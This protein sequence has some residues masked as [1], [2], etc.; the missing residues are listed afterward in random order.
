[1]DSTVHRF[2]CIMP[3][4]PT[5]HSDGEF[6]INAKQNEMCETL[7][8][9][10]VPNTTPARG[11]RG[12]KSNADLEIEQLKLIISQ[13]QKETTKL[14]RHVKSQ[15]AK[16][17]ARIVTLEETVA[18]RDETISA[19]Q[20]ALEDLRLQDS[21][22][23][24]IVKEDHAAIEKLQCAVDVDRRKRDD[25]FSSVVKNVNIIDNQRRSDLAVVS[26]P[27]IAAAPIPG[28]ADEVALLLSSNLKLATH[29]INNR[30]VITPIGREGHRRAL[31]KSFYPSDRRELF[32]RV[33]SLKP[34]NLFVND[35]LTR[36]TDT[37]FY[38]AR[39]FKRENNLRIPVFSKKGKIFFK[40][41]NA[42]PREITSPQD[43]AL[44]IEEPR[45]TPHRPRNPSS[46]DAPAIEP[47][48]INLSSP[49]LPP[50]SVVIDAEFH[51]RDCSQP[52]SVPV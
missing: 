22:R 12:Q 34:H 47:K 16:F 10:S 35:S 41:K 29:D 39:K 43:I 15:D 6:T 40:L 2:S 25:L 33:K 42:N 44:M 38:Q 48:R 32:T 26:H 51:H 52:P 45:S 30:Y 23:A 49:N 50:V 1:M 19:L 9:V 31:I 7:E 14:S 27:S 46:P 20:S 17:N 24:N 13:L 5:N 3:S 8:S 18:H 36:E 21:S 37:L 28:F 11:T 4:D